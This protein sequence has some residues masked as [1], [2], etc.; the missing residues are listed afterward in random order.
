MSK[1]KNKT[2]FFSTKATLKHFVFGAVLFVVLTTILTWAFTTPKVLGDEFDALYPAQTIENFPPAILRL[3]GPTNLAV[4]ETGVWFIRAYD[5]EDTPLTYGATWNQKKTDTL[6]Q[7]GTVP[8]SSNNRVKVS[9]RQP[10]SYII[11]F[12]VTDG[13]GAAT[14]HTTSVRV[15]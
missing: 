5:P 7:G 15:E 13:A 12:A 10:G 1:Y 2:S 3:S 4:G 8:T 6:G 9:F 14:Y 11:Q